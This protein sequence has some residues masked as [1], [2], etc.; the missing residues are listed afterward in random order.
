MLPNELTAF[1][2][3]YVHPAAIIAE[4]AVRFENVRF[5]LLRETCG[6]FLLPP[7][8]A[9]AAS[10]SSRLVTRFPNASSDTGLAPTVWSLTRQVVP[11]SGVAAQHWRTVVLAQDTVTS[12]VDGSSVLHEAVYPSKD[13]RWLEDPRFEGI[14]TGGG[15]MGDMIRGWDWVCVAPTL[16]WTVLTGNVQG[17]TLLGPMHTWSQPLI[18]AVAIVLKSPLPMCI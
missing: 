15:E 10:A 11:A 3:Q 6:D 2:A 1:L 4:G 7:L 18:N 5:R 8:L 17:S 16:L 9:A 13:R 14:R 12:E